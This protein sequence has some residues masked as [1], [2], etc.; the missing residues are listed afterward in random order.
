MSFFICFLPSRFFFVLASAVYALH[1]PPLFFGSRTP[2][3]AARWEIF[4]SMYDVCINL[5][6]GYLLI[7]LLSFLVCRFSRFSLR[8]KENIRYLHSSSPSSSSS[9]SFLLSFFFT[10]YSLACWNSKK[11]TS[12]IWGIAKTETSEP[13]KRS[14]T[15][16]T[17]EKYEFFSLSLWNWIFL[18]SFFSLLFLLLCC[19]FLLPHF[20]LACTQPLSP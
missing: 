3:R 2:Q 4:F 20:S 9:S 19:A 13:K 1:S 11:H 14:H 5:L 6:C 18:L 15:R 12:E 10:S 17:Y 7:F 16:D 8:K